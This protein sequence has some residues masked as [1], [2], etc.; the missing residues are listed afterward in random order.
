LKA[1]SRQAKQFDIKSL[2]NAIVGRQLELIIVEGMNSLDDQEFA[3]YGKIQ[4]NIN[5]I[6]TATDFCENEKQTPCIL[7]LD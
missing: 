7:K 5:K 3:A 6:F 1:T 2:N 4:E